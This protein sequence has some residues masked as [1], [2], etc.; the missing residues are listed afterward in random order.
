LTRFIRLDIYSYLTTEDLFN[1]IAL[2]NKKERF[3]LTWSK[4][5]GMR[6]IEL[7][8]KKLYPEA[9]K[10]YNTYLKSLRED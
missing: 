3:E 5:V 7:N 8:L 9:Q 1:K 6:P 10:R 4:L 2:L